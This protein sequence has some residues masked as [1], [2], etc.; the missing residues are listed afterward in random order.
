MGRKLTE[1]RNKCFI[2]HVM[3]N[4][5][6]F[7]ASMADEDCALE[8]EGKWEPNMDWFYLAYI[9][10]G[11]PAGIVRFHNI[12]NT[13]VEIHPQLLPNHWGTGESTK[14]EEY[15]EE[16]F[17]LNTNYYKLLIQSPQCCK[18]VLEATARNG[19]ALEGILT[20]AIMWRGKF[21][22]IVLMSKFI[23]RG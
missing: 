3:G 12:S 1:T 18:E 7:R 5:V 9:K 14:L 20:A 4:K 10:D 6:L 15:I 13:T 16:W 8:E 22:N 19:Y 21:E 23:N 11:E 17:F 2:K